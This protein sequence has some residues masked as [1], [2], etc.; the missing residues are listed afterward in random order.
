M[1]AVI[2]HADAKIA[3][4]YPKDTYRNLLLGLR[5]NLKTFNIPMVHITI[6]G[7]TGYG[8][9]NIYVDADPDDI[10]WNRDKF[11]IEYLKNAEDD[12]TYWFTEPDSRIVNMF[13]PLT[14][15][16]ALIYRNKKGENPILPGWRLATK[17]AL[18]VFETVFDYFNTNLHHNKLWDSDSGAWGNLYRML[19]YPTE[20]I[21]TFNDVSIEL[22][23]YKQYFMTG[24]FYTSQHKS[25][26]KSRLIDKEK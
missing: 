24:S 6:N 4:K 10:V 8:D 17:K 20:N 5:E 1:K 13:P 2:Y 7:F 26:N 12:E 11:F 23:P 21:T 19:G 9:E 3:E 16:L 25:N 22:R 15:D 14:T 18:P